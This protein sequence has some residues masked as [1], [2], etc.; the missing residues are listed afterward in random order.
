[1]ADIDSCVCLLGPVIPPHHHHNLG[2][3]SEVPALGGD[4]PQP[5]SK[6]TRCVCVEQEC[7]VSSHWSGDLTS[8]NFNLEELWSFSVLRNFRLTHP[9]FNPGLFLI[10]EF[11]K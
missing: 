1:M 6:H 9:K 4:S 8:W 3:T 11:K 2:S 7:D 5:E 10:A